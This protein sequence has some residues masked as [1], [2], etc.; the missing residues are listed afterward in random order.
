MVLKVQE[1]LLEENQADFREALH[2]I[3]SLLEIMKMNVWSI[4]HFY[5]STHNDEPG[6]VKE[7]L[8]MI[9][10]KVDE[11]ADFVSVIQKHSK[12]LK[13]AS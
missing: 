9:D 1:P 11:V 13:A 2:R 3:N 6:H 7:R 10:R 8:A 12:N 5:E 4:H